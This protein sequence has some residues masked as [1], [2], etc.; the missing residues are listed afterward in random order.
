MSSTPNPPTN[1]D[2]N[3]RAGG[4]RVL[5]VAGLLVLA[6]S[7]AY[8]N[9]FNVPLLLDDILSVANNPSIRDIGKI[10]DVLSPSG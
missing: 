8:W 1:G 2:A 7:G 5:V 6:V 9:S 3:N 10:G 4:W